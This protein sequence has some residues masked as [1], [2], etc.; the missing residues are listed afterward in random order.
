MILLNLLGMDCLLEQLMWDD[1]TKEFIVET[2]YCSIQQYG[3]T[4]EHNPIVY[5]LSN[6]LHTIYCRKRILCEV[7]NFVVTRVLG[8]IICKVGL[9]VF[10][11]SWLGVYLRS[12]QCRHACRKLDSDQWLVSVISLSTFGFGLEFPVRPPYM[13]WESFMDAVQELMV[14]SFTTLCGKWTLG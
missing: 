13:N 6:I 7:Q 2:M 1:S 8:Y 14:L 11:F 9:G 4:L 5:S 10:S 12:W 3:T